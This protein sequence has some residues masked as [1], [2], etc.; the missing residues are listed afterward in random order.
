MVFTVGCAFLAV[1]FLL[2]I[3]LYF[4]LPAGMQQALGITISLLAL[5]PLALYS[6]LI[7][8]DATQRNNSCRIGLLSVASAFIQLLGYGCGFLEAWWKRCVRGQDE[9]QAYSKNFYQ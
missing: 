1:A 6:V 4:A 7:F 2:G 5:A 3:V 8:F 9:F